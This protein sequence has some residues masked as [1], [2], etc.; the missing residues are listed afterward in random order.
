MN[1]K[2][3]SLLL[4]LLAAVSARAL[5]DVKG[6]I[7]LVDDRELTGLITWKPVAR[8]YSISI[9]AA[10]GATTTQ[11]IPVD[12]VKSIR[13]VKPEGWDALEAEIRGGKATAATLPKLQKIMDDYTMLQYDALAARYILELHLRA[14]RPEEAMK[15]ADKLIQGDP[16]AASTSEAAPS[17]WKAMIATGKTTRL[18]RYLD[19]AVRGGSRVVSAKALVA[20]GDLL[21][22]NGDMKAALKNG[23]LRVV[24]LYGDIP[25]VQPEALY[26]AGDAFEKAGQ[27]SYAEKMRQ[28]LL[29]NPRYQ[30]SSWARKLRGN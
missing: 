14:N 11:S 13:V 3:T 29:Q 25:E 26:K 6:R 4:V 21:A 12:K 20:R 7:T 27:V 8:Q 22:K 18:E 19:E 2:L 9:Q 16:R 24:C 17:I 5:D 28:R 15:I 10:G 1:V 30:N 23:Y